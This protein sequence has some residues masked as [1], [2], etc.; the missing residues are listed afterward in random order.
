M[1]YLLWSVFVSLINASCTKYQYATLN[2]DLKIDNAHQFIHENDTL[3]IKY[4]FAGKNCPV[5]I[6]VFNKIKTPIYIDWK[7]SAL[8]INENRF[9]YW[10]DESIINTSSEGYDIYW[11]KQ[12]STSRSQ[13]E[14]TIFRN[15]RISFIPS[16]SSV[17]VSPFQLKSDFFHLPKTDK[18]N[19]MQLDASSTNAIKYSYSKENSPLQF[20][21]YLTISI[22]EDFNSPITLDNQFWVSEIMQSTVEPS[23]VPDKTDN[24]F[25]LKENTGFGKFA[26]GVIGSIV[27][28]W[29]IVVS[30]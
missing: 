28:I 6:E 9:S 30:K 16:Q 10:K 18:N 20:R 7:K 29:I 23:I 15:E 5:Q 27:I 24:Q 25:Y 12:V 8:I 17:T 11:T 22:T 19:K 2:S 13:T 21:S 3:K 14:G 4:W 1:K 26:A